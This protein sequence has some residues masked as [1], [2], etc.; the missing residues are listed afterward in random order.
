M[1][2]ITAYKPYIYI[3]LENGIYLFDNMSATG[4]TRLCRLLKNCQAYREPVAA[5]TYNDKLIGLPIEKVLEP[6]KYKVILLDRYDM[7]EGDGKELINECAKQSIILID[8]KGKFTV[9][10]EEELCTI[11][12]EEDKIEVDLA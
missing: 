4:K 11:S 1:F 6:G 7:Y 9:T 12:L 3:N 2:E 10:N 5:Y 8:C